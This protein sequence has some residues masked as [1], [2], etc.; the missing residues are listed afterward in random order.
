MRSYL[1]EAVC[2]TGRLVHVDMVEVNPA[3]RPEGLRTTVESA[4]TILQ[5]AFGL[6]LL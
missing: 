3:L 6:R 4:I 5:A 2:E 1:A